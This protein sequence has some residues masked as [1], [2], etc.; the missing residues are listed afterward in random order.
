MVLIW[1]RRRFSGGGIPGLEWK[2]RQEFDLYLGRKALAVSFEEIA[3]M[4]SKHLRRKIIDVPQR[5]PLGCMSEE[6]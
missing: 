2:Y 5:K 4:I 3:N 6:T 1:R